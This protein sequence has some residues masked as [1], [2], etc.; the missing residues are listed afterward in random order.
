MNQISP[1]IID[2]KK[3]AKTA[4]RDIEIVSENEIWY[5][6]FGMGLFYMTLAHLL[7]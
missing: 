7:H 3:L 5:S 6:T 4:I 1:E 2:P